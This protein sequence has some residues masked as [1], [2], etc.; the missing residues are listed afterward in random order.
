M[1]RGNHSDG[2]DERSNNNADETNFIRIR[3]IP[4]CLFFFLIDRLT[5]LEYEREQGQRSDR[6]DRDHPARQIETVAQAVWLGRRTDRGGPVQIAGGRRGRRFVLSYPRVRHDDGQQR[7]RFRVSSVRDH[8]DDG[9]ASTAFVAGGHQQVAHVLAGIRVD[10]DRRTPF[11]VPA[12]SDAVLQTGENRVSRLLFHADQEQ[13]RYLL[14]HKFHTR[15]FGQ[16]LLSRLTCRT[17][18]NITKGRPV[19]T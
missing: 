17:A 12:G 9:V 5:P 4:F 18:R 19:D 3:R 11:G 8:S 2:N 15:L 7:N 16:R 10:F 1:A 14:V 13:R 6:R